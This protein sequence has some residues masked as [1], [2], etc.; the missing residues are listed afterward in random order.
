MSAVALRQADAELVAL[1]TF[2]GCIGAQR[3]EPTFGGGLDAHDRVMN[4]IHGG[5]HRRTERAAATFAELEPGARNTLRA[6]YGRG[7]SSFERGAQEVALDVDLLVRA[8]A[9]RW[10][11]GTFLYVVGQLPRAQQA[12]EKRRRLGENVIDF[13]R[14]E[15]QPARAKETRAFFGALVQECDETYRRPA[16]TA[17]DA[18]RTARI[19]KAQTA[20]RASR[21]E[22]AVDSERWRQRKD[23]ESFSRLMA[24]V[25]EEDARDA[26]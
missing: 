7:T 14:R 25:L 13:L 26:G 16:L 23:A 10:G 22:R 4:Q 24:A 17:Y 9:P 6:I 12:W 21:E 15:A 20:R 1:F 3:Y 5:A 19:E 8:L 2:T 18:L 11:H